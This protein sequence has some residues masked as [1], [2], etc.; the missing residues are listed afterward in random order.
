MEEYKGINY[1]KHIWE[2]WRVRDFIDELD[3]QLLGIMANQ[4]RVKPLE[5]KADLKAWCMDNQPYYKR[6]IPEVVN[7]FAKQYGLK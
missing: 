1:D 4:F 3:W 7:H 6:Y 2:G 5:T